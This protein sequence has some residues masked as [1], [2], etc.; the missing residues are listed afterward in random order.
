MMAKELE[1]L[2]TSLAYDIEFEYNGRHC[3]ICPFNRNNIALAYGEDTAECKSVRE[4]M[5]TPLFDGKLLNE[6]AEEIDPE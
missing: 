5:E 3:S 4:A 6:I 1:N 2:I